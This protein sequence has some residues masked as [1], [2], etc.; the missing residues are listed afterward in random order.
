MESAFLNNLYIQYHMKKAI[1]IFILMS[2]I[3]LSTSGCLKKTS[4]LNAGAN[5]S[6][7]AMVIYQAFGEIFSQIEYTPSPQSKGN[8]N[9]TINSP[10]GGHVTVTGTATFDEVTGRTNW[11]LII[12]WWSYRMISG[13]NDLTLSGQMSYSGFSNSAGTMSAHFSSTKLTLK[14]LMNGESVDHDWSYNY[15][16]NINGSG[17]GS[18]SGEMDGRSFSFNF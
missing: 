5:D 4:D 11:M 10:S 3:L 1:N 15:D 16:I 6:Q 7:T 8:I 18:I 17:H 13:G 9:Q 14:G 2:V 12:G